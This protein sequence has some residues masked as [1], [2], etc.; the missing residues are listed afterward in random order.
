[1]NDFFGVKFNADADDYVIVDIETTGLQIRNSEIIEI[2]ALKVKSGNIID[3]FQTFI[4]PQNPITS[5]TSNINGITNDMVK[6]APIIE[7]AISD[8]L[9]FLDDNII[10]GHNLERFVFKFLAKAIKNCDKEIYNDYIDLYSFA[11]WCIFEKVTDY[12]LSTLTQYFNVSVDDKKTAMRDCYLIYDCYCKLV[13]I[14]RN[15]WDKE[16]SY[17]EEKARFDSLVN[18]FKKPINVELLRKALEEINCGAESD[19]VLRCYALLPLIKFELDNNCFEEFLEGELY[20]FKND[21]KRGMFKRLTDNDYKQ[22][23][24]DIEYCINKL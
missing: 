6:N 15:N 9:N 22:I 20:G 18:K 10:V 24:S 3:K 19:P 17:E 1:M 5:E 21:I 11:D 8:F 12:K 7:V 4:K 13:E 16:D 14:Y 2:A 23:K